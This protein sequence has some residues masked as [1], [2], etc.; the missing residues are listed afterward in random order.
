MYKHRERS[1]A[2]RYLAALVAPA[3]VAGVMQATW[4]LLERSPI[5]LF[6]LA[7]MFSAWYGGLGPGLLSVVF[8]FLL[9]RFLFIPPYFQF[10]GPEQDFSLRLLIFV[11]IGPFICVICE[12]MLRERR[13][14]QLALN[15]S[16]A[17]EDRYRKLAENFPNGAVITYDI[18]LRVTFIAGRGLDEAG[19]S[20]D[21]FIGKLLNEIA[22][23]EVV[24]IAEPH[25]RAAFGGQTEIYECP[26]PD[27][28][29]YFCAVAPLLNGAGLITE[30][31]V[32]TQD[33]TKHK[34][35]EEALRASEEQFRQLAENIRE[36]FWLATADLSKMLYVSPAYEAVWGRTRES[37][38]LE[39]RSF[40]AAI[41]DEDRAPVIAII[42]RDREQGFEVEYRRGPDGRIDPLDTRSWVPHKR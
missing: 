39:P 4:P 26:Y 41:Q 22:P 33:L 8:S 42:E 14:H 6:W 1:P 34:Q 28:R 9:A 29:V 37:L 31:Q 38:Y 13:R 2:H 11:I 12:L 3:L 36:V 32:I 27:G 21:F 24:A 16:R 20:P 25:F 23:P 35:A 10:W 15:A 7:V 40:S 30:I 5:P 19:F 18:D 17:H